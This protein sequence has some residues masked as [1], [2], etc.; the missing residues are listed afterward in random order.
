MRVLNLAGAAALLSLAVTGAHAADLMTTTAPAVAVEAPALS[1]FYA[2]IYGGANLAGTLTFGDGEAADLNLGSAFGG[3]IGRETPEGLALELDALHTGRQWNT[4]PNYSLAS[5]S[6]MADAK[7]SLRLSDAFDVYAGIGVGALNY[8][9]TLMSGSTL[10]G[11]GMGYQVQ[12]GA[13]LRFTDN[14]SAFA[15]YRYQN[16]FSPVAVTALADDSVSAPG[17]LVLTGLKLGF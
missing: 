13:T 9:E 11:W 5:T 16:S 1:G 14:L 8:T 10:S 4:V 3:A 2:Q 17:N 7:Y 12:L 6:I 15:E